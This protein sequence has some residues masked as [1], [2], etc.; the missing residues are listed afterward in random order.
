MRPGGDSLPPSGLTLRPRSLGAVLQVRGVQH[1]LHSEEVGPLCA[2]VVSVCVHPR[3]A[4]QWPPLVGVFS[5]HG[6]LRPPPEVGSQWHFGVPRGS[7]GVCR[8]ALHC[9]RVSNDGPPR[10]L[11][12]LS[13]PNPCHWARC[14]CRWGTLRPRGAAGHG[15]GG[16]SCCGQDPYPGQRAGVSMAPTSWSR[17]GL[18]AASSTSGGRP[19]SASR[20][21]WV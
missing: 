18:Q 19:A 16:T 20:P 15:D 13:C 4:R 6:W 12:W 2:R 8:R 14:P 1:S 7:A 10:T 11:P 3:Q 21:Q 17:L 5:C 9:A